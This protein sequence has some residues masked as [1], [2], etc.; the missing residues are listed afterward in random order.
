M[1]QQKTLRARPSNPDFQLDDG[2]ARYTVQSPA[3]IAFVLKKA[4]Q[5]GQLV[6]AYLDGSDDFALTAIMAVLPETGEVLLDKS[7]D[8]AANQRL[9]TARTVLLITS[10]DQVRIKFPATGVTEVRYQGRPA[11]RIALPKW[12]IRIQRR[13]HY[14]IATPITQPLICTIPL[15]QRGRGSQAETIVLDISIGGVALMDNHDA[16][17]FNLGDRYELCRIGLP[18]VG[19]LTVSVEVRNAF[20]TPLKNGLSFRR[21]GCQF[22]NLNP[23]NES[24]VQRYIMH[25]ERAR[26]FR[27][28]R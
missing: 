26:N 9:L 6:T 2:E 7:P 15:P 1:D 10:H 12:L 17:G 22:L 24:L 3:E 19:T 11:F 25:L 4:M 16:L 5:N 20:N 13:E 28:G 18:E 27:T 14:R 23:A 21:C 8:A